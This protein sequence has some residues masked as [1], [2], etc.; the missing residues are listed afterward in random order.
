MKK[1]DIV[2]SFGNTDRTGKPESIIISKFIKEIDNTFSTVITLKIVGEKLPRI[3]IGKKRET[4]SHELKDKY[5]LIKFLF[6]Y[7]DR[8]K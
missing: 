4:I 8:K 7:L 1:G 3:P 5:K 2:Y 6:W